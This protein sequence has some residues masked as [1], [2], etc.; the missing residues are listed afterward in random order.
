MP[1]LILTKKRNNAKL[2]GTTCAG[3][4]L[5][6]LITSGFT[7]LVPKKK[8]KTK[9]SGVIHRGITPIKDTYKKPA[10]IIG[11]HNQSNLDFL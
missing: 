11:I 5:S 10:T 3:S 8:N 4:G 2:R 1:P 7:L 9:I 6:A